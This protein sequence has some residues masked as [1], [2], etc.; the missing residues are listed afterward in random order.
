MTRAEY[1][2][3]NYLGSL[4]YLSL[5]WI[6]FSLAYLGLIIL[7]GQPMSKLLG[8]I[9]L[10]RW[11]FS[12]LIM[13]VAF[14]MAQRFNVWIAVVLTVLVYNADSLYGILPP[15]LRLAHVELPEWVK[16]SVLFL[17]PATNSLDVL[18]E[19]LLKSRLNADPVHWAFLSLI[20]Y[21]AVMV[22]LAWLLFRR[23][24]LSPTAE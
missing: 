15:L 21:C 2:L 18:F 22:L 10:S 1:L 12:V 4:V 6:I 13:S 14:F 19:S 20:D 17:F 9:L 23:Q 7:T 24:E 11:V 8:L 5:I 16:G 3:G